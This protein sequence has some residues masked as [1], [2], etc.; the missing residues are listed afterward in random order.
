VPGHPV[1]P[2]SASLRLGVFGP[3]FFGKTPAVGDFVRVNLPA[4]VCAAL[5]AQFS[6][7]M[8]LGR[9][10]HGGDWPGLFAAAPVWRYALHPPRLKGVAVVGAVAPSR[11]RVGRLYPLAVMAALPAGADI[12]VAPFACDGWFAA[13]EDGLRRAT[14]GLTG[15]QGLNDALR[16]VGRPDPDP[17]FPPEMCRRLLA[18][19]AAA[20]PPDGAGLWWS[21]GGGAEEE[22]C[23]AAWPGLPPVD[24]LTALF[25]GGWRQWSSMT[26]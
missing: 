3:G 22:A 7:A 18:E 1:A 4:E 24:R 19:H 17:A 5:D 2:S 8:D 6:D 12:A 9:R 21:L 10:R 13:V 16:A 15:A 23:L 14:A 11:D 20:A 26:P 25:D